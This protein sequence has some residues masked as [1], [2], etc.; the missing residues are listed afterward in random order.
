MCA[1]KR[2]DPGG[3]GR[4]REQVSH[5]RGVLGSRTPMQSRPCRDRTQFLL[6]GPVWTWLGVNIEATWA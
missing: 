4:R 3:W 5:R 6:W 1:E 2:V